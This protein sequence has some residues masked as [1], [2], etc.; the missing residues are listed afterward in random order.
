MIA[1]QASVVTTRCASAVTTRAPRVTRPACVRITRAGPT[2]LSVV[3]GLGSLGLGSQSANLLQRRARLTTAAPR[4]DLRVRASGSDAP[5]GNPM[6]VG[7]HPLT[8][9]APQEDVFSEG[10]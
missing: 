6:A 1:T 2:R 7:A 5:A 3:K 4:A 8:S 10:S 9:F